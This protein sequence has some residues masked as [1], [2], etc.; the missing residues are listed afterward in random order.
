MNKII[1]L[2][3]N[4]A[5]FQKTQKL[6]DI[7]N[8]NPQLILMLPRFDINLGFG[9]KR[10]NEVCEERQISADLFIMLCNVY[11]FDYYLPHEEEI[12]SLDCNGLL[13]YLKASHD[14]YLKQRLVHIGNHL[15]KIAEQAG[16]IKPILLKFFSDYKGEVKRHF[17]A[18]EKSIFPYIQSLTTHN[19]TAP[20]CLNNVEKSHVNINNK[21]SELTNI[22]IKYLSPDILP[23]ERISVWFDIAQ[24]SKDLA[25]HSII[26]EKILIPYLRILEKENSHE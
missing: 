26:E 18:E 24:L 5:L 1:S 19:V 21:L 14:Y 8:E 25:K 6:A 20:S 3:N 16:P 15:E 11:T 23:N 9:E 10:A 7:L 13:N 17:S 2:D 4:M 12:R 22:L